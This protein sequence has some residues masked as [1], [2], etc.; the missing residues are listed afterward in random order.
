MS[1]QGDIL[2]TNKPFMAINGPGYFPVCNKSMILKTNDKT[3]CKN[4]SLTRQGNFSPTLHYLANTE[5][6]Q[7][8]GYIYKA[9]EYINST[10]SCNYNE[11]NICITPDT[12]FNSELE[13]INNCRHKKIILP[14]QK[15]ILTP[16]LPP[17]ICHKPSCYTLYYNYSIINNSIADNE[18]NEI[19]NYIQTFSIIDSHGGKHFLEARYLKVGMNKW[20]SEIL[21]AKESSNELDK[22]NV[23]ASGLIE[24]NQDGSLSNYQDSLHHIN[25]KWLNGAYSSVNIYFCGEGVFHKKCI[26][27]VGY[28]N[29]GI[30]NIAKKINALHHQYQYFSADDV[31]TDGNVILASNHQYFI[32]QKGALYL[33]P[34][35]QNEKK[36]KYAFIPLQST[37][38]TNKSIIL[39]NNYEVVTEQENE[40]CD[41][42]AKKEFYNEDIYKHSFIDHNITLANS[43]F[44]VKCPMVSNEILLFKSFAIHDLSHLANIDGCMLLGVDAKKHD[45]NLEINDLDLFDIRK[46]QKYINPTENIYISNIPINKNITMVIYDRNF[47][48][49]HLDINFNSSNVTTDLAVNLAINNYYTNNISSYNGSIKINDNRKISDISEELNSFSIDDTNIKIHWPKKISLTKKNKHPTQDGLVINNLQEIYLEQK[50]MCVYAK[51][52]KF[53]KEIFCIALLQFDYQDEIHKYQGLEFYEYNENAGDVLVSLYTEEL[54]I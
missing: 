7:L 26:T 33:I 50:N 1:C 3:I 10:I 45:S 32:D 13:V 22:N 2:K 24:F 28:M 11:N 29:F 36:I 52:L 43:F 6:Q 53:T 48:T 12:I 46:Y 51:Y 38:E 27:S 54:I 5:K 14:T 23:F 31:T 21:C 49:H 47:I 44:A 8:M 20:F 9:P 35:S 19:A 39:F 42:S 34:L 40:Q 18:S 15:I 30:N 4:M 41:I 17:K 16:N 25:I 37:N